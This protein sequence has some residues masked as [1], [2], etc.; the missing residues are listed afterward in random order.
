MGTE[1]PTKGDL[2]VVQ[3]KKTR[4]EDR[5]IAKSCGGNKL[6][7]DLNNCLNVWLL[8]YSQDY[9]LIALHTI[10]YIFLCSFVKVSHEAEKRKQV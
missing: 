1:A 7:I 3:R 10:F 5:E 4:K 6:H 9:K 2:G 8:G